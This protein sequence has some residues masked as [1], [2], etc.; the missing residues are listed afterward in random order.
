MSTTSAGDALPVSP[1]S[2]RTHPPQPLSLSQPQAALPVL[3]KSYPRAPTKNC[4][5][6]VKT[7]IPLSTT[8]S[9][10]STPDPQL[11]QSRPRFSFRVDSMHGMATSSTSS[12]KETAAQAGARRG[13]QTSPERSSAPPLP[14]LYGPFAR[15]LNA[16]ALKNSKSTPTTPPSSFSKRSFLTCRAALHAS[17]LSPRPLG[18]VMQRRLL[19]S[20][21]CI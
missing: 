19:V 13:T 6:L 2:H 1:P 9:S 4:P 8:P 10:V 20:Y 7:R 18:G 16:G 11:R 5:F 17:F 3:I 15:S 12:V 14:S 21:V